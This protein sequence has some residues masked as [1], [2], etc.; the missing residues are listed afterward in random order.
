MGSTRRSD[1]PSV[2]IAQLIAGPIRRDHEWLGAAIA[3]A[4]VLAR[5]AAV[6]DSDDGIDATALL[7]HIDAIRG[8]MRDHFEKEEKVVFPLVLSGRASQAQELVRGLETEHDDLHRAL[9][10]TRELTDDLRT[11]PS[12]GRKWRDLYA[13]LLEFEQ[14]A[15]AHTDFEYEIFFPRA[16]YGETSKNDPLPEENEDGSTNRGPSDA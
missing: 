6:E 4:A 7:E 12:L 14:R 2:S 1:D 11:P 5:E 3:R 8:A 15:R 9:L 16:F 13:H 10:R